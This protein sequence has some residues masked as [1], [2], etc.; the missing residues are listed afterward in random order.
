VYWRCGPGGW[1]RRD[2]DRW[3][4]LEPRTEAKEALSIDTEVTIPVLLP[5]VQSQVSLT[6]TEF[7]DLIRPRLAQTIEALRRTLDS[8]AL[9]PADLDAVLLVG[10]SSRVPLV[11]RLL[12]AEL[13]RPVAVDGDPQAAIA[14]GAALSG[15]PAGTAHLVSADP[16]SFTADT[17]VPA[18]GI[19]SFAGAD[20]PEP[21]QSE[22]PPWLTPTPPEAEP[23]EVSGRQWSSRRFPRFTV[24]RLLGLVVLGGAVSVLFIMTAHRGPTPAAP[25]IPAPAPAPRVPMAQNPAPD[26]RA[27]DLLARH[28]PVPAPATP[29]PTAGTGAAPG[30]LAEP[31][32]STATS[33]VPTSKAATVPAPRDGSRSAS[34]PKPPASKPSPSPPPPPPRPLPDWV[35]TARS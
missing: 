27:Q 23:A 32:G 29:E 13:G 5:Q 22:L 16:A 7:E 35:E 25:A 28:P 8:A 19:T 24:V 34:R 33:R 17:S 10:G 11:A 14:L 1:Q 15:R 9:S 3:V 6:R 20:V 18:G 2:F 12:S 30:E 26:P 4:P 21:A 31:E